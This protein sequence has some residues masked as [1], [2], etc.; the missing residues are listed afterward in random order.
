MVLWEFVLVF[1]CL[2][3]EENISKILKMTKNECLNGKKGERPCFHFNKVFNSSSKYL[4]SNDC[5][6]LPRAT[7]LKP[8]KKR[9]TYFTIYRHI[10]FHT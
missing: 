5:I 8:L 4:T 10:Y 6:I 7:F 3:M 1:L 2:Q 9:L